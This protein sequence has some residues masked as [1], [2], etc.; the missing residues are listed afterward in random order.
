MN[1]SNHI[2]E[3][4]FQLI[5]VS[6]GLIDI[7]F[8]FINDFLKLFVVNGEVVSENSDCLLA[9]FS[10]NDG[11]F[12]DK[13]DFRDDHT[14]KERTDQCPVFESGVDLDSVQSECFSKLLEVIEFFL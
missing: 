10:E 7:F 2:W 1:S 3:V 5:D 8:D 9:S 12:V 6:D 13:V 14:S 4:T 11:D